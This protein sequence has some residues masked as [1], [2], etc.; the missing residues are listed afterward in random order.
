MELNMS[1]KIKTA[2][3]IG[4]IA[5][6]HLLSIIFTTITLLILARILN[7]TDFG[8][9]AIGLVV[10]N[11][12][13]QI[14]DLGMISAIVHKQDRSDKA[15]ATG[16][17]LRLMLSVAAYLVIAITVPYW[18][19]V[20]DNTEIINVVR[21]MSFIII[22]SNF[23]FPSLTK[24]NLDLNFK[25]ISLAQGS[26]TLSYASIALVLTFL[27]FGYWSL[28]IGHVISW[29]VWVT[30]INVLA[31]WKFKFLFDK[32]LA[33]ELISYG[34]HIL[35]SV[36]VIFAITNVDNIIIAAIFSIAL[37]GVYDIAYKWGTIAATQITL[38]V[39]NVMFPTYSK[40]K[41]NIQLL[42]SAYL[43]TLH[44]VT[45]LSFPMAIGLIVIAPEFIEYVLTDKWMPA[46]TPL[47]ILCLFGLMRSISAN[48]G[49]I[50]KAVGRPDILFKISSLSLFL[51]LIFI[52]IMIYY[53]FE[54]IGV[55]FAVTST[56]ILIT[57]LN[58]YYCC[59]FTRTNLHEVLNPLRVPAIATIVMAA[60]I[61]IIKQGLFQI[62]ERYTFFSGIFSVVF[63]IIIGMGIYAT[64]IFI[65]SP[66]TFKELISIFRN[67]FKKEN[68][69]TNP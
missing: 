48:S 42:K 43:K 23:G 47:I 53:G 44:Y 9:I 61:L 55:A 60:L 62:L 22:I 24:L 54:I 21:I 3:N 10:L 52:L 14:S 45:I 57:Q 68:K 34:K 49:S 65:L 69:V 64:L 20:F 4:Y 33:K 50:F 35:G 63:L 39:N 25:N 51:K 36:V 12:L 46:L 32:K 11:A 56:S 13:I 27:G 6:I 30:V 15:L 41:E 31:P 66:E 26:Q 58:V 37:L 29:V 18:A 1:L 7:K 8:I 17:L 2:K 67:I 38:V 19:T 5:V 40:I 16:F 59:K 28:V